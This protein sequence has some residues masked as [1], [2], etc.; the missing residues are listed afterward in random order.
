MYYNTCPQ[1]GFLNFLTV[2]FTG[3]ILECDRNAISKVVEI[4]QFARVSRSLNYDNDGFRDKMA[5]GSLK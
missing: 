1:Q 2:D 4:D 5:F 3:Y